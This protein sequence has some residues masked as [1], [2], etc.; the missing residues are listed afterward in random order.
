MRAVFPT[1]CL[2]A[3]ASACVDDGIGD[4]CA[5]TKECLAGL[6]CDLPAG[7]GE[8]VC[9]RPKDMVPVPE[10]DAAEVDRPTREAGV[11]VASDAGSETSPVDSSPR[12][13]QASPEAVADLRADLAPIDLEAS[14]G[15]PGATDADREPDGPEADAGAADGPLEDIA[16][17]DAEADAPSGDGAAVDGNETDAVS[18][19][20]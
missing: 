19:P 12:P 20:G 6:V 3:T 5:Q 13:D 7:A 17:P 14:E 18:T 8:G 2:V 15:P 11:D 10:I 16:S 9:R 1:A 4:K